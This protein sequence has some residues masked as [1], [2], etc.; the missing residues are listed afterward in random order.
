MAAHLSSIEKE[1]LQSL[2]PVTLCMKCI[3]ISL[4]DNH[5]SILYRFLRLLI[6]VCGGTMVCSLW[7]Y[8]GFLLNDSSRASVAAFATCIHVIGYGVLSK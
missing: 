4:N 2:K 5:D 3:G 8:L 6:V 7:I 1:V